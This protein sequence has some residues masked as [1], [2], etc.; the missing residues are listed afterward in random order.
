[1]ENPGHFAP[2]TTYEFELGDGRRLRAL[3]SAAEGAWLTL[4]VDGRRV[5]LHLAQVALAAEDRL[6]PLTRDTQPA[7]PTRKPSRRSP[8]RPWSDEELRLLADAFLD[9]AVNKDLAREFGRTA[10]IIG[11]LRQGFECARGNLTEDQIDEVAQSWVHRWRRVL[12]PG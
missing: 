6:P 1:M 3:V 11:H 5:D 4:A 9:G 8:G 2:G 12:C 10:A 7:R